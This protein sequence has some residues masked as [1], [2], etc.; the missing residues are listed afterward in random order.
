MSNLTVSAS[1]D[2]I[3]AWL[4]ILGGSSLAI[5]DAL[6]TVPNGSGSA[7]AVLA[8]LGQVLYMNHRF[9]RLAD[10]EEQAYEYGRKAGIR[11][12]K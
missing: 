2:T 7:G 4:L 6:G 11:S 10:R 12:L 1:L 8:I 3:L 5:L 9:A